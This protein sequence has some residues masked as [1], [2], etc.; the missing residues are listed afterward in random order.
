MAAESIPQFTSYPAELKRQFAEVDT[1]LDTA[2]DRVLALQNVP[3]ERFP[4]SFRVTR[5]GDLPV[6]LDTFEDDPPTRHRDPNFIERFQVEFSAHTDEL[7]PADWRIRALL[8]D[9]GIGDPQALNLSLYTVQTRDDRPAWVNRISPRFQLKLV[10][11]RFSL[12]VLGVAMTEPEATNYFPHPKRLETIVPG[13][14]WYDGK[15]R[16]LEHPL[17][18]LG[19]GLVQAIREPHRGGDSESVATLP[20]PLYVDLLESTADWLEHLVETR[21]ST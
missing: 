21:I 10:P 5:N 13:D 11:E 14:R 3:F 6:R 9:L 19:R 15:A 18:L 2:R 20:H 4:Q 12:D 17:S 8:E 7:R 1:R 16:D